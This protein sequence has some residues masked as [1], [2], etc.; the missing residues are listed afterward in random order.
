MPKRSDRKAIAA[1]NADYLSAFINGGR[2]S[3]N[4]LGFHPSGIGV[5]P[6]TTTAPS[7]AD[8]AYYDGG[9][10]APSSSPSA[11]AP[12]PAP[13]RMGGCVR[14]TFA[15]SSKKVDIKKFIGDHGKDCLPSGPRVPAVKRWNAA[16]RCVT[17]STVSPGASPNFRTKMCRYGERCHN[18][19]CSY[20]HD[21][22]EL[23]AMPG[24]K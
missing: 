24:P 14:I 22:S 13:S 16:P 19:N 12:A 2:V 8:K 4:H 18:K 1:Q 10:P 17:I 11:P 23:R 3:R 20:A 5:D 7:F 21:K 9:A 15:D 6:R